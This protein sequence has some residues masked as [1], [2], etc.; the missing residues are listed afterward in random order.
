MSA[1]RHRSACALSASLVVVLMVEVMVTALAAPALAGSKH[2]L[3]FRYE[4]VGRED[5]QRE[6]IDE[7]NTT[8]ELSGAPNDS[9]EFCQLYLPPDSID[10]GACQARRTA[11]R[12]VIESAANGDCQVTDDDGDMEEGNATLQVLCTAEKKTVLL[13]VLGDACEQIHSLEATP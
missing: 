4:C 9:S 12:A 3:T 2:L 1:L 11:M 13:T 5:T 6:E 8:L 7:L 10:L